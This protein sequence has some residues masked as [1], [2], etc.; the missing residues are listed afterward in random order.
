[1]QLYKQALASGKDCVIESIRTEGEA[2]AL[3]KLEGFVLWAVDADLSIRHE[4][5]M[6]ENTAT[7]QRT[8]EQF[9]ADEQR[10]MTSTDKSKQNLRRCIEISD[11]VFINNGTKEDLWER[12]EAELRRAS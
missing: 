1:M 4:R 5:N 8:L 7:D 3:K 11:V 2:E 10:E 6:R 12:I 9:M